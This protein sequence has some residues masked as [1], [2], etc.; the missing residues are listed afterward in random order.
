M[1]FFESLETNFLGATLSVVALQLMDR[2]K[3]EGKKKLEG[4]NLTWKS[5]GIPS[6]SAM[7]RRG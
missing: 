5:T 4:W 2:E 1:C 7:Q 6:S 3:K